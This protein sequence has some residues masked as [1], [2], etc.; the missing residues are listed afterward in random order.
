MFHFF[1]P[2]TLNSSWCPNLLMPL[3]LTAP[4]F[5][6]LS[7]IFYYLCLHVG[8]TGNICFQIC[9]KSFLKPVLTFENKYMACVFSP[10]PQYGNCFKDWLTIQVSPI[11]CNPRIFVLIIRQERLFNGHSPFLQKL[12]LGVYWTIWI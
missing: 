3:C 9:I 8:K 10:Y 6:I 12:P 11:R 1:P 4:S 5:P 2:V 7:L